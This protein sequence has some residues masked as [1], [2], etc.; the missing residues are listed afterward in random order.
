MSSTSQSPALRASD[1]H[2][3]GRPHVLLACTGSVATIKLPLIL[4]QLSHHDISI[5]IILSD[6]ASQFL[7]GQS[8]E[9]PSV[10]SLLSIKNV[11]AIYT[12]QDEWTLPWTRGADILHIEL[13]RW[14]DIMIIVP[15]SANSMAKMVNGMADNLVL[16]VARAWDTTGILDPLR[17][18]LPPSLRTS[19]GKKPL[20]VAP[21]MNTAMW[22]HPITHK[23]TSVLADEWGISAGGW[24]DFI[25]PIEKELACGDTGGGAMREWKEIVAIIRQYLGVDHDHPPDNQGAQ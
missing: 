25:R 7:Q 8:A 10:S 18:H 5:R 3:D 9:Q 23:Q 1:F 4:Q 20:L 14:A 24:I 22:A 11:D 19:N 6:S 13:R 17:P 2:N 12:D 15:L 16:S 21:A